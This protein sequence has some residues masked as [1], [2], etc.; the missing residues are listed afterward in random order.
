MRQGLVTFGSEGSYDR[1]VYNVST[2]ILR[3]TF[4]LQSLAN[5]AM[6]IIIIHL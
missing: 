5:A 2:L 3:L 6:S 4:K 1:L